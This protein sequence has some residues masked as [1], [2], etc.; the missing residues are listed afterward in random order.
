MRTKRIHSREEL[1]AATGGN[2]KFDRIL[3]LTG[4]AI[5]YAYLK[6]FGKESCMTGTKSQPAVRFY[7]KFPKQIALVLFPAR[8]ARLGYARALLWTDDS[9][10]KGIDRR[11]GTNGHGENDLRDRAL[12]LRCEDLHDGVD[13]PNFIVTLRTKDA[14]SYWHEGYDFELPYLDSFWMYEWLRGRNGTLP[15][16]VLRQE[17][18]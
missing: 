3:I 17:G 8:Q 18:S 6:G 9:G 7:D 13:I 11:Y 1:I 15:A 5:S 16:L 12:A 14:E 10:K 4:T 2:N